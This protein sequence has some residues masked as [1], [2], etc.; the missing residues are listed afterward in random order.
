MKKYT[1]PFNQLS[2]SQV[3]LVVG[4][5]ASLGEMFNQLSLKGIKIPDGFATTAEAFWLFLD[6]NNIRVKLT[7]LMNKI[8]L[9]EFSNLKEIGAEAR[10]LVLNVVI[11]EQIANEIKNG[12]PE[13]ICRT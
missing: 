7:D 2:N 11:H 9:K 6:E 1:L 10:A 4:K 8:D 5:N 12:L 3:A 13:F